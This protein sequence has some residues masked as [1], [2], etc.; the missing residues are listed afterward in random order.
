MNIY[1]NNEIMKDRT[2][3]DPVWGSVLGR[4]GGMEKIKKSEYG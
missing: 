3:T 2:Q 1:L 4:G